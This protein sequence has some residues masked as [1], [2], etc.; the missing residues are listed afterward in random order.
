MEELTPQPRAGPGIGPSSLVISARPQKPGSPGSDRSVC[1][2]FFFFNLTLPYPSNR[3]A[4]WFD[5]LAPMTGGSKGSLVVLGI[6]H[7]HC[8]QVTHS[9]SSHTDSV[10]LTYIPT[11][12][13]FQKPCPLPLPFPLSLCLGIS[14]LQELF[15]FSLIWREHLL[16]GRS[17]HPCPKCVSKLS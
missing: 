1:S 14:W 2:P 6:F 7:V 15:M 12:G 13:S 4:S 3:T 8:F 5:L 10:D 17:L 11:Y 16:L 9:V